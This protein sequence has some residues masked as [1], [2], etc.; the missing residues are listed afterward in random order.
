MLLDGDGK[1]V[2]YAEKTEVFNKYLCS[3]F[4]TKLDDVA[5]P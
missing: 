4:G 2:N 1:I 5:T 3:V